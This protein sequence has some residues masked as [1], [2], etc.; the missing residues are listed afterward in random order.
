MSATLYAVVALVALQRVAELWYARKNTKAL[1]ERG[2]VE[3]GQGHYPL[4]V[5]LHAC[6]LIAVVLAAPPQASVNWPLLIFFGL[7]QLARVWIILSLGP[8]WTTRI[9]TLRGEPLVQRGPYRF[10]R[11]PNYIVVALEIATLPAAF[12]EYWVAAAFSLA[13]VA[14][15]TW[16]IREEN[17]ALAPRRSESLVG[18]A[19]QT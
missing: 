10:V 3:V 5:A 2:A 8:Y 6:W 19:G 18:G 4:I 9:I 11:H 16:R 17:L 7:L 12:D 14:L 13:N 15:L 1:L